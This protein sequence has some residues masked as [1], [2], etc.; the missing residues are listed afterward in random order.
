MTT[1]AFVLV[2]Y[3]FVLSILG[4]YGWHRYYL[5]YEYRKNTIE[6]PGPPPPLSE[7]PVVTVQLPIYNEMYVADRLIDAVCALDYPTDRLEIQV[8]DDSTDETQ[9]HRRAGRAAARG[10]G[11]RHHLAAPH[12]PDRLQ[13][14][15]AR[16]TACG[17]RAAS[18]SR[19][20]TRISFPRADF[21]QAD[22]PVSSGTTKRRPS[23]RRAGDT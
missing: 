11:V 17:R 7:W 3:F 21:L 1:D 15:R 2:A 6:L 12:R 8:L 9:R 20:S 5:V 16:R 22:G 18:S 14:G 13:G 19:S 4:I 10:A 23:C